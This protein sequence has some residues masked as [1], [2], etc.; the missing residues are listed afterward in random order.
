MKAIEIL[1]MIREMPEDEFECYFGNGCLDD[2]APEKVIA[3]AMRLGD[4]IAI[5]GE[6]SGAFDALHEEMPDADTGDLMDKVESGYFTN[7]GNFISED[8]TGHLLIQENGRREQP[9]QTTTTT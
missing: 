5:G 4:E 7:K 9:N 2:D 3:A 6:H 1:E 8:E